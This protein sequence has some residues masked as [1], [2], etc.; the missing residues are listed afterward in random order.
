MGKI[1]RGHDGGLT[2]GAAKNE[3][4]DGLG[5]PSRDTT[6]QVG[7]RIEEVGCEMVVPLGGFCVGVTRSVRDT[8][9][10]WV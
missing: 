1:G 6:T 2:P 7:V 4:T 5:N 8:K 9:G 10:R 3:R